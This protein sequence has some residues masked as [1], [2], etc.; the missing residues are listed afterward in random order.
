MISGS[1][2]A[3][4]LPVKRLGFPALVA[5]RWREIGRRVANIIKRF[6]RHRDY[7]RLANF[8]RVRAF[9]TEWKLLRRPAK[10]CLPNLTP[11]WDDWNL[12]AN[13]SDVVS[14]GIYK[15][16][17]NVAIRFHFCVNDTS[18]VPMVELVR[19]DG[20]LRPSVSYWQLVIVIHP[21]EHTN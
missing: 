14:G 20:L 7:M 1:D 17:M 6:A 4:V 3:W 10:H 13:C 12:G 9:D 19:C 2:C 8:Q 21:S 16:D 15:R 18:C 11:L 5:C